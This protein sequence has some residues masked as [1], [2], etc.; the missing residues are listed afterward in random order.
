MSKALAPSASPAGELVFAT[1]ANKAT[2]SRQ[3]RA[4]K[5]MR[6]TPGV[7]IVGATLPIE[8]VTRAHLWNVIAHFWPDAVICDR[9]AFDGG[10]TDWI[11]IC[12]P[13]PPR[14]SDLRLHGVTVTCRV[15]PGPLPGD[16]PWMG[17]P[18][19]LASTARALLENA[20]ELGRPPK[21]RPPRAAGMKAVGDQID[22]LASSGDGSRLKATFSVFD[23]IHGYFNQATA[24]RV[25]TLLAAA[26]G[27]YT[28]DEIAS[29]RLAARVSGSPYDATRIHLFE[30]AVAELEGMAP[31]VRPDNGADQTRQWLPFYEAYFSNYI[32]G[33]RFSV[34]EA[35]SIAIES[36]VPAA[37]PKDAHDVSATYHIVSDTALMRQ[38]PRDADDLVELLKERHRA[39]M[40]A[41]PEKHPGTIKELP[42]YAGATAFVAPKQVEGTLRAGWETMSGLVDPFHRAVMMMFLVS[43]CHPFDDGN[44]R[45]ARILTNAELVA[46]GQHRIVIANSYRN[47]YLAA[48][49][50]A[51]AGNGV[52]PLASALDFTRKWVAA[53]NWSDWDACRA[54]LNDSH[55]FEDPGVAEHSGDR[56]RL[57]RNP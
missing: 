52:T 38:L 21:A 28:G 42:N 10:Q 49:T 14:T 25:R 34:E 39:L 5:A 23:Q 3:R 48:L 27:T 45:V 6:L 31:I 29:E 12:H 37:R 50:G 1:Q 30:K 53:V 46:K 20:E 43:E 47:N 33:T 15:G 11:F 9:T 2:L 57:P 22:A 17:G 8:A 19:F 56:L 4:G 55:A 32:E 13:E 36:K 18:L 24:T 35:Y 26:S 51:T 7:Y 16:Q 41:R 54:D 40:A 44:G